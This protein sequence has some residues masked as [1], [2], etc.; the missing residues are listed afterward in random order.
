MLSQ[1]SSIEAIGFDLFNTLITVRSQAMDI[2]M[3]R[4]WSSLCRSSITV[5]FERLIQEHQQAAQEYL[6]TA[7]QNGR[8]THNRFWLSTALFRLGQN[9]RA[10][11]PR[12]SDAIEAY[13]SAFCDHSCLIPDTI[14]MLSILKEHYCL[15]IL[16]NFTHAPVVKKMLGDLQLT[17]YFQALLISDEIG[18]RKPKE[19]VFK[20]LLQALNVDKDK[21]I[22]IGDDPECDIDGAYEAGIEP[23]WMTYVRDSNIPMA[24]G[25]DSKKRQI[26]LNQT[27]RISSWSELLHLLPISH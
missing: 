9:I 18:Y 13:F 21:L 26:P 5:D 4:L 20:S 1:R 15:G 19:I 24:P 17:Q 27:H 3:E 10:D 23:I 11:D 7:R 14:R 2:A 25:P 22:Y 12:I 16:S 6:Q 8:E